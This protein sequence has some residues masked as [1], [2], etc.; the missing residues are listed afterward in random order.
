MHNLT[1]RSTD[2]AGNVSTASMTLVVTADTGTPT[3]PTIDLDA[4]SDSGG[5]D[6]DDV[7]SDATPTLSGT[8]EAGSS[9]EVFDGGTSLGTTTATGGAW[10]F[11]TAARSDGPHSFTA[12]STDTAGNLSAVSDALVVTIDTEQPA[13]P[14][15]DL[16][17]ASDSGSSDS[18]NLTSV[19]T[20]TLN[21]AAEAGSTVAIYDNGTFV[22]AVTA[23]TDG[24]WT[25]TLD[26]LT[27]GPHPLTVTATDTSGNTSET[28]ETLTVTVDTAGPDQPTIDLVDASDTG[29]STTDDITSDSTPTLDG[30]AET[31]SVVNVY[32]GATLLQTV[33]AGAGD[34]WTLTT[35]VLDDGVHTLTARATDAAGNVS[36]ASLTLEITTDTLA[37]SK[38]TLDLDPVSDS[39]SSDSDN[40]TS[41]TT[42]VLN[43]AAEAGSTVAISDG[44][45]PLTTVTADSGGTWT[46]TLAALTDGPH[47][48]TVTATDTSGNTSETSETLTVTVDTAGPDQP[49]IDLATASDTGTS[50]TDNVTGDDTPTLEGDAETGSVVNVY[51]GATLLQT[52][53]AGAGDRWTLTTG[54]LDDG[55]HT[56]T[57][58]ATDAAGNISAASLTLEVTTD[59]V[60]PAK[61]T[62]D[63]DPSSDSGASDSDNVTRTRPR[64][65]MGRPRPAAP[66][67]SPTAAPR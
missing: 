54:V 34:R 57:A 67:P 14:T 21:G 52:V 13:Q 2:A 47:P 6:T 12:Q 43:G 22:Q 31:G 58:K 51:D 17:T 18:D 55:V 36:I 65:S 62:L 66:S 20:P 3:T 38:P 26:A 5:S 7:T 48:L 56:L 50:D 63:L 23:G 60:A 32:D 35:G 33:I 59:T 27:D 64:R 9:V 42:P 45:T 25:A 37:P 15:V 19:T 1:A 29:S 44:S 61:P 46:A 53:I 24:T 28:S 41:V 10:S 4:A 16:A 49:S 8:A 30:D 40:L 11:T 39:G